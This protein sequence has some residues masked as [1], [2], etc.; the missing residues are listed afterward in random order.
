MIDKPMPPAHLTVEESKAW[1]EILDALEESDVLEGIK[2]A[3]Y[4]GIEIV[5]KAVCRMREYDRIAAE[6]LFFTNSNGTMQTHPAAKAAREAEKV[7]LAW[8]KNLG[9]SPKDRAAIL[10]ELKTDD[11]LHSALNDL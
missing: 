11:D 3:D 4:I 10:A 5:A 1:M 2:P 6:R 8:S 7:I 9:L